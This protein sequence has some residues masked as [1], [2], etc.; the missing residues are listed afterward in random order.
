M[1][2]NEYLNNK[3]EERVTKIIEKLNARGVLKDVDVSKCNLRGF[4][5]SVGRLDALSWLMYISH[6]L[7]DEELEELIE[8][9]EE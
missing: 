2:R 7:T 9:E 3:V 6:H 8:S 5:Y 1:T 4:L